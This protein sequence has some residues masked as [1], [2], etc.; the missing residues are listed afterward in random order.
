MGPNWCF[1]TV[2]E[3]VILRYGRG[4]EAGKGPVS[5]FNIMFVEVWRQH[6]TLKHTQLQTQGYNNS[7]LRWCASGLHLFNPF[8]SGWEESINTLGRAKKIQE[9]SNAAA[10]SDNNSGKNFPSESTPNKLQ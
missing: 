5:H 4:G 10:S 3:E 9:D 6:V 1:H 7:T 2:L 8:C